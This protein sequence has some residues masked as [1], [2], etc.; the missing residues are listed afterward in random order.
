MINTLLL[1][2]VYQLVGELIARSL[3]LP[4]PGPV[5]GMALLFLTP[6]SYTH[7]DVYKRQGYASRHRGFLPHWLHCACRYG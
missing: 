1:L 3:G 6:V 5:L 4:V 7:L 2:L